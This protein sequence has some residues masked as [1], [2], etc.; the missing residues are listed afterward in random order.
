[1]H[2]RGREKKCTNKIGT[3]PKRNCRDIQV[4]LQKCLFEWTQFSR[5]H[6]VSPKTNIQCISRSRDPI[7]S[8]SQISTWNNS[9][10][11]W[12][13][14]ERITAVERNQ[15]RTCILSSILPTAP[16]PG[17]CA[18][19]YAKPTSGNK[20]IP[21]SGI[22]RTVLWNNVIWKNLVWDGGVNI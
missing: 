10:L 13:G 7:S 2:K 11:K 8:Q 19:I 1:M 6:I 20:P 12:M 9:E 5:M 15:L 14:H 21:F 4:G 18:A 22:A 16:S 17:L 3:N